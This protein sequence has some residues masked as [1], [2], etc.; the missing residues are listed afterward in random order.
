MSTSSS[1]ST[2][3]TSTALY[4]AK[5]RTSLGLVTTVGTATSGWL[6]PNGLKTSGPRPLLSREVLTM[7]PPKPNKWTIGAALGPGWTSTST[8]RESLEQLILSA[9]WTGSTSPLMR[10]GARE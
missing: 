10:S 3:M 2:Q 4:R 7:G 1:S 6:T 8:K 5:Y 9:P